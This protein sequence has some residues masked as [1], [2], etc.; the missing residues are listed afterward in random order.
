MK[1]PENNQISLI[2][3][4]TT[5]SIVGTSFL[6]ASRGSQPTSAVEITTQGPCQNNALLKSG[7]APDPLWTQEV[8]KEVGGTVERMLITE[9]CKTIQRETA[10]F[11]DPDLK[12]RYPALELQPGDQVTASRIAVDKPIGKNST[13]GV[14]ESWQVQGKLFDRESGKELDARF[15]IA[16]EAFAAP[17]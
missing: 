10:I 15:W 4:F 5:L 9:Q 17:R 11:N 8:I 1:S 13:G 2:R 6:Y 14:L 7:D 16:N 3:F 12:L